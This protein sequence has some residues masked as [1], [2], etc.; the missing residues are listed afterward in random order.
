MR[1]LLLIVP[2]LAIVAAI[3]AASLDR[4]RDTFS[5]PQSL[6]LFSGDFGNFLI[7]A[8]NSNLAVPHPP[9]AIIESSSPL[10]ALAP[11][12]D[13]VAVSYRLPDDQG[14]TVCH[15]SWPV[16]GPN[17]PVIYKSV[18]GIYSLREKRW[19]LYGDFCFVGSAAFSPDGN[20]VAFKA[21]IRSGDPRFPSLPYPDE[22]LILDLRTG[23]FKV[24]PDTASVMGNRL[25]SWSPDG[26]YLAISQ[27]S[28]AEKSPGTIVLIQIGTWAK[29]NIAVGESPSWS[30]KGDWIAYLANW[31]RT[32]VII[33]PDG[34]GSKA[35]LDTQGRPGGWLFY[36]WIGWSADEDRLLL[37]EEQL[38][39]PA[40]EVTMLNVSNGQA[41]IKSTNGEPVWGWAAIAR[42]DV[43][44]FGLRLM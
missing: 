30:P 8:P 13:Q 41:M 10:P 39:G 9:G 20:N 36:G 31:G 2:L 26:Q 22:L 1:N 18:L 42:G 6:L 5:E 43:G 16:S 27:T 23:Q 40:S 12:G 11:A 37:N 21:T 35:I 38:D 14:S 7:A 33:H 17:K 15:P 19:K 34:T 44:H 32:C 24:V 3:S 4:R 29:K 28:S 25:L